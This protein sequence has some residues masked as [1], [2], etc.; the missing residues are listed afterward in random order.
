MKILLNLNPFRDQNTIHWTA[1]I[2]RAQL[3][4]LVN[5]DATVFIY[6]P[7]FAVRHA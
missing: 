7:E 1:E 2:D 5:F 3:Y 4:P 6:V